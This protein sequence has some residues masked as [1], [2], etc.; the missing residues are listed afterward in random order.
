MGDFQPAMKTAELA[1]GSIS[2]V[3]VKGVHVLLAH[4]GGQVTAFSGICTHEE[5]DLGTGFVIE[6]RVV[7]PLHLSQFD[8][9]T[10]EAVNPPATQPLKRFNVKIDGG[11]IFVEV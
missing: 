6:D 7:C 10:G 5:A 3:D 8:L 4:V 1:E 9:K 11:T 2:G